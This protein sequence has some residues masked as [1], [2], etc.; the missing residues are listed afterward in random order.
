MGDTMAKLKEMH[1]MQNKRNTKVG[2]AQLNYIRFHLFLIQEKEMYYKPAETD[3]S[4]QKKYLPWIAK[5]E[6]RPVDTCWAMSKN[7]LELLQ[8]LVAA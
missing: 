2:K 4:L 5:A 3:E 1:K 7:A 6:I 8:P